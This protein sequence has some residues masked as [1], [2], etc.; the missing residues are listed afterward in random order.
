MKSHN[1]KSATY[2]MNNYRSMFAPI[3]LLITLHFLLT[4][5]YYLPTDFT[6]F[7]LLKRDTKP[8]PIQKGYV[9]FGDSFA[10]GFGTGTTTTDSCRR[11]EFSYPKQLNASAPAGIDFQNI[12]CSGA[13]ITEIISGGAN[14]QIDAWINPADS[15]I[16]TLSI[17]GNDVGFSKILDACVLQSFGGLGQA[18]VYDCQARIKD[19][20]AK[21][22][23]NDL[24]RNVTQAL[25][26]IVTKSGRSD[27]KVY[28]TGYPA[29][30]N[31]DTTYCNDVTFFYSSPHHSSSP[32]DDG[33][34]WLSQQLRLQLNDLL[35]SLNQFLSGLVNDFNSQPQFQN[36]PQVI[37][38]PTDPAFN[39]HRFCE[40]GV[41][42][43]DPSHA[44][45]WFFLSGWSD[46]TLPGAT[47]QLAFEDLVT[48]GNATALPDPN[49]C[50]PYDSN[51]S[52]A[53]Q[54]RT[55]LAVA[56]SGTQANEIFEED[57]QFVASG[58]FSDVSIPWWLPTRQAKTFHPKTL[59]HLAY[60]NAIM[61]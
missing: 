59:G 45:T 34:P 33:Y 14:S 9:A 3:I 17:G 31:V 37:F 44:D 29:F 8:N 38:V 36:N 22:T 16:A 24:Y 21:M 28:F 20:T 47:T 26:E 1:S 23:G 55:A 32:I 4:P 39:G 50:D 12:A 5:A 15:D 19:A 60:K 41:L 51:S 18:F 27:F 58:E 25:T 6:D 7:S 46:D 30:F 42:E 43:P 61:S 54:C 40:E 35:G 2:I 48:Q 10:A 53:F 11:G 52:V 57:L 49:T 13:V 56:T